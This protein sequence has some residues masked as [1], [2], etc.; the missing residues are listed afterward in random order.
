M[1][2]ID[3]LS[4]AISANKEAVEQANVGLAASMS[5]ADEL[6]GQFQGLG[7]DDK[8]A[9]VEQV[10]QSME[11]AQQALASAAQ[12]VE[13]AQAQAEALRGLQSGAGG[14]VPAGGETEI[15]LTPAGGQSKEDE[16]EP[17]SA[18]GVGGPTEPPNPPIAGG[19]DG[20]D[21]DRLR[22]DIGKPLEPLPELD[23]D[24]DRGSKVGRVGRSFLKNIGDHQ[25]AAKEAGQT[26]QSLLTDGYQPF[27][28]SQAQ[29]STESS[30]SSSLPPAAADN[31]S[32]NIQ[33]GDVFGN[34]LF[35]VGALLHGIGWAIDSRGRRRRDGS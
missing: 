28:G 9:G 17:P 10:K 2:S 33:A 19:L 18:A 20:E 5:S 16:K 22:D 34:A 1:A 29:T 25:D 3:E 27:R 7:A 26:A 23:L 4:S 32:P 6:S 11:Q 30:V 21:P 12:A 14:G 35:A 13:T 24:E 31:E 8:V 15:A